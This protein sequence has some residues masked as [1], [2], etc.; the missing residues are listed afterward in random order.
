MSCLRGAVPERPGRAGER[1]RPQDALAFVRL[2][3]EYGPIV[4]YGKTLFDYGVKGGDIDLLAKASMQNT[5]A[6]AT[7]PGPF[8]I[9]DSYAIY[10]KLL[11]V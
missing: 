8:T 2:M 4:R 3:R 1:R 7:N 10:H 9:E 5:V 6:Y 11:G